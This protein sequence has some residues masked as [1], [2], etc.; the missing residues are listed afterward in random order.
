M[1]IVDRITHLVHEGNRRRVVVA[2]GDRTVAQ[3]P[4]TLAVIGAVIAP[5]LA[6]I[7]IV[8]TLVTE[9]SIRVERVDTGVDTDDRDEESESERPTSMMVS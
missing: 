5:P 3:F 6:V 4:L 9:S 7:A 2:R 1:E 8:I